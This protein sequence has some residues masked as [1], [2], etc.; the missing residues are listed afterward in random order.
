MYLLLLGQRR[1]SSQITC[2]HDVSGCLW[3][4]E[5]VRIAWT[6][7]QTFWIMG[8]TGS[9]I[10]LLLLSVTWHWRGWWEMDWSA[11][12]QLCSLRVCWGAVLK[13]V[14]QEKCDMFNPQSILL[15][16]APDWVELGL[17]LD[18]CLKKEPFGLQDLR[19]ALVD[20]HYR[21]G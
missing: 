9:V 18:V 8:E 11:A 13:G 4:T 3:R 1:H 17:F 12:C 14:K 16:L 7:V 19:F 5:E 21:V 10:L 2:V 20:Q 15:E 6:E